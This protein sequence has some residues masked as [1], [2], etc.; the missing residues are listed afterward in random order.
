M[1]ETG[2]RVFAD[3]DQVTIDNIFNGLV[4]DSRSNSY[5]DDMIKLLDAKGKAQDIDMRKD[6]AAKTYNLVCIYLVIVFFVVFLVCCP[7]EFNMSDNALIVLLSTTTI[8]VIGLFAIVM[9]YLF[10]KK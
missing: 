6:F 4:E 5:Y 9:N 8:N 2:T 7:A 1:S 10:P 3:V